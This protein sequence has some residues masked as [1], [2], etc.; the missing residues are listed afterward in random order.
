[1]SKITDYLT[2]IEQVNRKGIYQENWDSLARHPL[3][4]WFCQDKF[5]IFIHWGVYSVPAFGNEWY[6]RS[7]YIQGSREYEHHRATYGPQDKFGYQDFI[8]LFKAE[9]FDPAEWAELF[10]QAGAKYVVP[11]AEHHDGFQMYSSELSHWNAAEMGPKRD[12]LGEL[13]QAFTAAGLVTGASS[14]RAEH[15]FFMGHGKD[16][17]SDI[18]E[19]LNQ[20]DFYWPAMPEPDHFDRDSEPQPSRIFLDDWLAR[21][22]ELIDRY[23]PRLLYFDWWILHEAFAPYLKKMAAYYYNRAEEWGQEVLINYKHDSF[24]FGTAVVDIERGRFADAKPYY[25]QTDTSVA[26]DSWGY[27]PNNHYRTAAELL[28]DLVDIVSKNGNLLLNVGPKA[29]GTIPDEDRQILLEMGDWLQV[30]G[31]AI[32]GSHVWR[33]SAEGP[34][35]VV[36]GQFSEGRQRPYTSADVRYTVRGHNLY[37][38]ALKGAPDGHYD[39][40]ALG[41]QKAKE[42]SDFYG[43]IRSLTQLGTTAQLRYTRDPRGLHLQTGGDFGAEPIVFRLEIG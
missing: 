29:D 7:M 35:P 36:A 15:W 37:A 26:L 25:W 19:P 16:F 8:P 17:K 41:E 6:S 14:H 30:N 11:V 31:E 1:M 28:C 23:R 34:T 22:C 39:F 13:K 10:K 12:V 32:Y 2:L 9:K 20:G 5:G 18:H 42:T 4:N 40:P 24:M 27:T 3:P 33:K 38:I 43:S 21:T